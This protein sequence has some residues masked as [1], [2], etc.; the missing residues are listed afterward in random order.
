MA[1][2]SGAQQAAAIGASGTALWEI[3]TA[4]T[5][6]AQLVELGCSA[7][8]AT[9]GDQFGIGRPAAIG[10]TPTTPLTWLAEDPSSPAGTVTSALA[11]GTG[12]TA[13]VQFFRRT[14]LFSTYV[15]FWT[16]PQLWIP[17]SSSVVFWTITLGTTATV[18]LHGTVDA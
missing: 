10:I 11:W 9:S 3:R 15:V 14:R 1:I 8:F 4:S 12:P 5:N 7:N 18:D 2:Y 17:V 6:R 16:F 13:P